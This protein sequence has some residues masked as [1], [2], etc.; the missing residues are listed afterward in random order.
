[1]NAREIREFVERRRAPV[2]ELKREFWA[3]IT[4]EGGVLSSLEA[5]W[6]LHEHA[7]AVQPDFPSERYLADDFR[8]HLRVKLLLDRASQFLTLRRSPR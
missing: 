6:A 2:Q 7:R 3:S 8:D 4:R 5:G 1:V